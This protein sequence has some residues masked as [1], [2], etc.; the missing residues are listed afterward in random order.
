MYTNK[1]LNMQLDYFRFM[2]NFRSFEKLE[3]QWG[4]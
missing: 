4:W 3:G 1:E 2:F